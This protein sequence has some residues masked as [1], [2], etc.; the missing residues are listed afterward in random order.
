MKLISYRV[1]HDNKFAPNP[2]FNVL[3]LA[4]CKPAIRRSSNV[5]CGDWLVG[6]TAASSKKYATPV[7]KEKLIYLACISK[8]IP[9]A[10]YW[11]DYPQKRPD[12]LKGKDSPEFYGDNIYKPDDSSSSGFS[13][14][15][16]PFHR[17]EKNM[18]KDLSGKNVLICPEFFYFGAENALTVPDEIRKDFNQVFRGHKYFYDENDIHKLI[19]FVNENQAKC[20]YSNNR[21]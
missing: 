5:E 20:K 18:I 6:W 11:S 19:E 1:T 8:I 3:T 9:T 4:T 2:F 16:N 21:D 17:K 10:Q 15:K 12:V 14:V 7:G 13:L